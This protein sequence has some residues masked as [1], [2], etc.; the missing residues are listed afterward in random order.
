[1]NPHA[2]P[3]AYRSSSVMTAS[4]GQLVVMLY[5]GAG[6]FLRRQFTALETALQRMQSQSVEMA[7]SLPKPSSSS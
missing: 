6:R 4:P 5:D 2:S 3:H 1:M 7:S